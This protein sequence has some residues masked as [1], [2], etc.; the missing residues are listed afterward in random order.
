MACS[1]GL[2][3]VALFEHLWTAKEVINLLENKFQ[4][5]RCCP[6]ATAIAKALAT[7]TS[8]L[9]DGSRFHELMPT[10]L[11]AARALA[12]PP[13]ALA[14]G[15]LGTNIIAAQEAVSI[16]LGRSNA[17]GAHS[18]VAV[19]DEAVPEALAQVLATGFRTS[20]FFSSQQ[21]ARQLVT[22]LYD[23]WKPPLNA[24]DILSGVE[25]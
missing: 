6:N 23:L 20:T 8:D 13:E 17:H 2:C 16:I 21:E 7:S 1:P 10:T 15:V 3:D 9:S 22:F 5:A 18:R 24:I 19:V 4:F 11:M 14:A 25:H 12:G